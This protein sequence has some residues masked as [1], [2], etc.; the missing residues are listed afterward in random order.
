MKKTVK[1]IN[2]NKGGVGKS[3][4]ASL[5]LQKEIKQASNF[6][7]L[8]IDSGNRSTYK[9]FHGIEPFTNFV[10]SFSLLKGETIEK[11]LFNDLFGRIAESKKE[12]FY[13]DLGG[14]E[15]REIL[16]LF[17]SIGIEDVASFFKE[18]NIDAEFITVIKSGDR[19]CLDH[20][21]NVTETL[22]GKIPQT[23]M[24]NCIS[25]DQEADPI[26]QKLK[27]E[28]KKLN[29]KVTVFGESSGGHVESTISEYVRS[30]F[31]TKLQMLQGVFNKMVDKLEI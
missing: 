28:C 8:D 5:I 26:F 20:L 18:N 13:L 6:T 10:G 3:F 12:V 7:I 16:S 11:G 23:C 4:L 19:D 25:I 17:K 27:E 15:S 22:N 14:N 2:Q 30:G 24:V 1:I 21:K 29:I 31:Q 9:R